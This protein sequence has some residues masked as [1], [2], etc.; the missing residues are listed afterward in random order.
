MSTRSPTRRARVEEAESGNNI[1]RGLT[2]GILQKSRTSSA[3]STFLDESGHPGDDR[4]EPSPSSGGPRWFPVRTGEGAHRSARMPLSQSKQ[5]RRTS[6]SWRSTC[7]RPPREGAGRTRAG[8]V[9]RS[10]HDL[11]SRCAT[12]SAKAVIKDL[13]QASRASLRYPSANPPVAGK[14][15]PLTGSPLRQ[16]DET[17]PRHRLDMEANERK[18]E[19]QQPKKRRLSTHW[20]T[21]QVLKPCPRS[22]SIGMSPVSCPAR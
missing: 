21:S 19:G 20:Q 9:K 11:R 22:Q 5:R 6:P 13:D 8:S 1:L 10:V 15:L 16:G 2:R 18:Q 7:F 3:D 17:C 12:T 4:G 14:N